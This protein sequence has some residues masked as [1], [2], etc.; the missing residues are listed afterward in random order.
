MGQ[1]PLEHPCEEK[2]SEPVASEDVSPSVEAISDSVDPNFSDDTADDIWIPPPTPS[3]RSD[4]AVAVIYD[5]ESK[6]DL[7]WGRFPG[8]DLV[9][10]NTFS[11][12]G[13]YM[14]VACMNSRA[15]L[16][17]KKFFKFYIS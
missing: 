12:E 6:Q 11:C 1:Y 3:P 8:Q 14:L 17:S 15:Y 7:A 16:K 2:S 4:S 10:H 13:S 5:A 9:T